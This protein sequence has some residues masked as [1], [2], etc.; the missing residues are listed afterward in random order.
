[1]PSWPTSGTGSSMTADPV[2]FGS[3]AELAELAERL[4]SVREARWILDHAGS[5]GWRELAARRL[6]GEPLQYVLGTWPFRTLE[7]TVDRRVLVPRPETEQVVE[8]ALGELRHLAG[9]RGDRRA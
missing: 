3:A 7:L 8:V 4:G 6:R 5:D 2:G 1:M 9:A